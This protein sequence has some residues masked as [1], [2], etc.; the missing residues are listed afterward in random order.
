MEEYEY[1]VR[2][3]SP[4]PPSECEELE[5]ALNEL[6]ATGFKPVAFTTCPERPYSQIIHTAIFERPKRV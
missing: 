2:T 3:V 4:S 1:V 5:R 6:G